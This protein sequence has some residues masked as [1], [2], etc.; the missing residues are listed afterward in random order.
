MMKRARK[1][2]ILM[3]YVLATKGQLPDNLDNLLRAP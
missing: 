3:A 1:Q 2:A